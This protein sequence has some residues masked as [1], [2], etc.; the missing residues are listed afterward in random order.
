MSELSSEPMKTICFYSV[1]TQLGGAERSLH[2][3]VVGL[4]DNPS[5]GYRPWVLFPKDKGP[6]IDLLAKAGVEVD[7]FPMPEGVLEMSRGTP[8][9]SLRRGM[10]ALPGM[11][12]Y[13]TR[14]TRMIRARKPAI[15]HTTGIKC[16]ALG[17]IAGG[18]TGTPVLWHLRD[19]FGL[20]P[21]AWALR[22]MR[23]A[24]RVHVVANSKATA[25]SFLRKRSDLIP[26][27]HNGIDANRFAPRPNRVLHREAGFDEASP[28]VGIIGALAG[29]KGQDLFLRMAERITREPGLESARFA[30]IGDEIYDTAGDHGV[31]AGLEKLASQLGIAN[32][33]HFAGFKKDAAEAINSLD[34]L[35]HA[36]VK[37]EPFGRV[38][39]EAMACGVPVV[40]AGDGGILELVEPGRTG[41][42]FPP[43]DVEAMSEGA[44]RLLKDESLRASLGSAGRGRVLSGFT[45]ER[46]RERVVELYARV[47]SE[48]SS[49]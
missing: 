46:H 49:R 16:H 21:T 27:I 7:V 25:R 41:I 13:L 3:L 18:A 45:L 9:G 33:V 20:G 32:R 11:G 40:A 28:L 47:L 37:P 34:V 4:Q 10:L 26:V 19:I 5:L 14:L 35:V 22:G 44:M 36:S 42:L 43:S 29:W 15:I 38:V 48:S 2:D 31:R 8:L 12:P 39:M 17:A 30:V 6:L 24:G 23:K 1:A